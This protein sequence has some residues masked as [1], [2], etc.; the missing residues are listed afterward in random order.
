MEENLLKKQPECHRAL[1][2]WKDGSKAAKPAFTVK[3]L[4][5]YYAVSFYNGSFYGNFATVEQLEKLRQAAVKAAPEW[6]DYNLKQL[7]N[8]VEKYGLEVVL[9]AIDLVESNTYPTVSEIKSCIPDAE[10]IL[11]GLIRNRD[12]G[13]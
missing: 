3:D 13:V 6:E 8:T 2:E 7:L 11:A 9:Y 5:E 1:F 12:Y 10:V 4:I